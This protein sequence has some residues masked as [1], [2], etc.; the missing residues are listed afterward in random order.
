MQWNGALGFGGNGFQ[1]VSFVVRRHLDTLSKLRTIWLPAPLACPGTSSYYLMVTFLPDGRGGDPVD[2]YALEHLCL[3][4]V[5]LS[6][7]KQEVLDRLSCL[8]A[9]ILI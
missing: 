4:F 3:V 1:L 9:R 5:L 2:I 7:S 8:P 6:A